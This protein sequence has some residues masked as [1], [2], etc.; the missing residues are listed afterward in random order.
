MLKLLSI[1]V[2]YRGLLLL[3][4]YANSRILIHSDGLSHFALIFCWLFRLDG[5]LYFNYSKPVTWQ[6]FKIDF[7]RTHLT[8]KLFQMWETIWVSVLAFCNP[9]FPQSQVFSFHLLHLF[10]NE[11]EWTRKNGDTRNWIMP[12][13][14]SSILNV[15]QVY[16]STSYSWNIIIIITVII[17]VGK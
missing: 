5:L 10:C 9:L 12:F 11:I 4:L 1:I 3:S 13:R 8:Y 7:F 15:L 17:S 16:R 2:R 14:D 6:A